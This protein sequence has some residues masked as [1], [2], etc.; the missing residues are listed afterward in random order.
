[1]KIKWLGHS[2]FLFEAARSNLRIL[3][4]PYRAGAYDGAIGYRPVR[5]TVD[6]VLLTHEHPDHA[7]VESLPGSPLVVRREAT[8]RGVPFET[9]E[10]AHDDQG[11]RLRGKVR[12][13]I[14]ELDGV[15]IAHLGDVGHSLSDQQL[16]ALRGTQVLLIP[17]GGLYTIDATTA[18]EISQQIQPNLLIPMHFK[19]SKVAMDLAPV[20]AFLAPQSRVRRVPQTTLALRSGDL[21]EPITTVVL[22]PDN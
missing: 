13:F 6:I 19:T 7:G 9:L 11:G 21:P 4:D 16:A 15:K 8:A 18:W 5:E 3:I 10:L 14:F 20:E 2:C 1:M 22:T 12:A 17:V